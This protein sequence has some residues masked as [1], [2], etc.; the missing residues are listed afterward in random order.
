MFMSLIDLFLSS[1][2]TG[3]S[4]AIARFPYFTVDFLGTSLFGIGF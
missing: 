3:N 4:L 1:S 2:D